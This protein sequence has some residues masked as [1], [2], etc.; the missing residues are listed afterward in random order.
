MV[1]LAKFI[2]GLAFIGLAGVGC[3]TLVGNGNFHIA[4]VAVIA[5]CA[6][7]VLDLVDKVKR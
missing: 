2:G 4:F 3:L 7:F 1:N 5:V 6:S